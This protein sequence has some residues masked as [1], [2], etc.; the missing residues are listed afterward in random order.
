MHYL[1]SQGVLQVNNVGRR[2]AAYKKG[3]KP[4][5][6]AAPGA[7]P[8]SNLLFRHVPVPVSVPLRGIAVCL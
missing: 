4:S 2:G 8:F 1:K 6:V 7:P 5:V 3:W